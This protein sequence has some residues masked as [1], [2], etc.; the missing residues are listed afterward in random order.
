[1]IECSIDEKPVST[2]MRERV[3]H[4]AFRLYEV[5]GREHGHDVEDWLQAEQEG[6]RDS[7][8][9]KV[10]IGAVEAQSSEM[11]KPVVAKAN[12]IKSRIPQPMRT[13]QLKSI[14]FLLTRRL[15]QNLHAVGSKFQLRQYLQTIIG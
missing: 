6:I 13:S 3:E 10:L 2:G 12:K 14:N 1:M 4:R 8:L 11:G 7:A 9:R 5:P 15:P